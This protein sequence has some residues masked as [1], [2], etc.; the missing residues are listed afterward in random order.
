M[1]N[2]RKREG[3][4]AADPPP[5][6]TTPPT[7]DTTWSAGDFTLISSNNVRFRVDSCFIFA[8]SAA[9]SDARGLSGDAN[10]TVTFTDTGFETK[11]TLGDF[12]SLVTLGKLPPEFFVDGNKY[13]DACERVARPV[14]FLQKYGCGAII[15]VLKAVIHSEILVWRPNR[16]TPRDGLP[17]LVLG[18]MT[19]DVDFC[20]LAMQAG[21]QVDDLVTCPIDF[22][23]PDSY[24]LVPINMPLRVARLIPTDYL[25]ALSY[26]W[27][28]KVEGWRNKFVALM[29]EV[30]ESNSKRT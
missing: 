8:A 12:F 5:D 16:V 30:K 26:S 2:K 11:E 18:A 21:C 14:T 15:E 25:W 17:G 19:D 28:G 7:D 13:S 23:R 4:T 22:C 29:K 10:K 24:D 3:A 20:V 9:F 27:P 6:D 1:N